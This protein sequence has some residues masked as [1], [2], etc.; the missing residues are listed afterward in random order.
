MYR[1]QMFSLVVGLA[2]LAAAHAKAQV[3]QEPKEAAADEQE[4]SIVS[5]Y[6]IVPGKPSTS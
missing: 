6:N 1:R 5:I 4:M 2:A 3:A